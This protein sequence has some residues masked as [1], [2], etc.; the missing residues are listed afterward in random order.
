MLDI[1]KLTSG[2][3]REKSFLTLVKGCEGKIIDN[4]FCL[5]DRKVHYVTYI[6]DSYK[7]PLERIRITGKISQA[8]EKEFD[9]KTVETKEFVLK[10][11][12]KHYPQFYKL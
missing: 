10:M 8:F 3:D 6:L 2:Y 4:T 12:K 7:S 9:M 11:L 1:D 5:I